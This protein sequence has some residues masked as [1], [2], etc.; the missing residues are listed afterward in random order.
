MNPQPDNSDALR[1]LLA[2]KRYELP[3]PR[4]FQ[5]F[6]PR[7]IRRLEQMQSAGVSSWWQWLALPFDLKPAF[8]CACGVVVC[9]LFSAGVIASTQWSRSGQSAGPVMSSAMVSPWSESSQSAV[10]ASQPITGS[11]EPVLSHPTSPFSQFRVQATPA[12]FRLQ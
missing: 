7:V 1:K 8:V 5:D 9:G 4:Y 2:L 6:P 3:P 10:L 12:S 11:T